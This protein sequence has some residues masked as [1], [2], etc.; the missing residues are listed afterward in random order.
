LHRSKGYL[1]AKIEE[2]ARKGEEKNLANEGRLI[3]D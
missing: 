2:G 3:D 1:E